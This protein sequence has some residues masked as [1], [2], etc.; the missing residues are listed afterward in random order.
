MNGFEKKLN[1]MRETCA[2]MYRLGWDER[3]GGNISMILDDNETKGFT[4]SSSACPT[5]FDAKYLAGKYILVTGTGKYLKNVYNDPNNNL[6]VIKISDD[7]A[8]YSVVWGFEDGSKPTSELPTHLMNHIERLKKDPSHRVVLHCHPLNVL[9]MTFVVPLDDITFTRALWKMITECV[10]VFPDGVGVLKWMI[11]G[12]K[13]IG[14]KTAEKMK[15][16]RCVVWAYHGIFGSGT[17]LDEAF[18]LVETVEKAA[19]IYMSICDRNIISEISD[20]QLKA[21]AD[22]FGITVRAGYLDC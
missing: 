2:N 9:A 20:S 14:L 15:E 11:C 22:A 13:E 5:G 21:V 1:M 16:C 18:G 6:G 7:G 17:S 12:G 4:G 10:I 8:Y 19:A 3:N